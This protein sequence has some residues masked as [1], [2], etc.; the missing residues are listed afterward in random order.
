MSKPAAQCPPLRPALSAISYPAANQV[1]LVQNYD[2]T[3]QTGTVLVRYSRDN[4]LVTQVIACFKPAAGT[5]SMPNPL[6]P[7]PLPAGC[8]SLLEV[9]T[10]N[11]FQNTGS[12]V[13]N[14]PPQPPG[15]NNLHLFVGAYDAGGNLLDAR[16][17]V[18]V[19]MP[20]VVRYPVLA[21]HCLW[22]VY[23]PPTTPALQPFGETVAPPSPYVPVPIQV[24]DGATRVRVDPVTTAPPASWQHDP[25]PTQA[26]GPQG[27]TGTE[28]PLDP[29]YQTVY[30]NAALHSA[31]ITSGNFRLNRLVGLWVYGDPTVATTE[32]D[33]IQTNQF[34]IPTGTAPVSLCLGFH[35]GYQWSNNSNSAPVQLTWLP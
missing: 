22:L 27:L 28:Q 1:V 10:T 24:P 33:V 8:F 7:G 13:A 30:Q 26:S 6:P 34:A 18:F 11:T 25:S 14:L 3:A 15:G 4:P 9:G 31:N 5:F 19:A 29:R 35:D 21:T 20:A 17:T 2:P 12:P 32:L 23:A 16:D